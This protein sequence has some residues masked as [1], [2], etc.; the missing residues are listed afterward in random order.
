MDQT[1]RILEQNEG[2]ILSQLIFKKRGDVDIP[3]LQKEI[4]VSEGMET[5]QDIVLTLTNTN[6][7]ILET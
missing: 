5:W 3:S 4:W 6:K 2:N 1:D 7:V